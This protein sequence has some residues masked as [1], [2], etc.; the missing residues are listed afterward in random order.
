V[1]TRL[2]RQEFDSLLAY[3]H[4]LVPVEQSL[5]LSRLGPELLPRLFWSARL[6]EILEIDARPDGSVEDYLDLLE[7]DP[8]LAATL[9]AR[10]TEARKSESKLAL[11]AAI[12]LLGMRQVRD[13]LVLS[14][15]KRGVSMPVPREL[16]YGRL[17]EEKAGTPGF[18]AGVFW[19]KLLLAARDL[20][21]DARV[22]KYI[23]DQAR[24]TLGA[25]VPPADPRKRFAREWVIA[26]GTRV[27]GA[28]LLV[29]LEPRLLELQSIFAIK[30]VPASVRMFV[31]DQK[32]GACAQALQVEVWECA[33]LLPG[34]EFAAV[35]SEAK[36]WAALRAPGCETF[37]KSKPPA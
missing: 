18:A 6:R 15:L 4:S 7:L 37:L 31:E 25:L 2:S 1:K 5:S 11:S 26:Q 10:A 32:F 12:P 9:V 16:V 29:L 28:S 3:A 20:G 21:A 35:F 36:S 23:E 8:A 24:S 33:G 30:K 22:L 17:A 14:E 13:A 19:E 27:A 34:L